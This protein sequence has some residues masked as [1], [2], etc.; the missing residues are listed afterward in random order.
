MWYQTVWQQ[1]RSMKDKHH[2][3]TIN[4]LRISKMRERESCHSLLRTVESECIKL[5]LS[6]SNNLIGSFRKKE[7]QRKRWNSW[8][9]KIWRIW[10]K[11]KVK[12]Q[13]LWIKGCK[14][15]KTL[16]NSLFSHRLSF[17][18]NFKITGSSN[19]NSLPWRPSKCLST[20]SD[21]AWTTLTL[22]TTCTWPLQLKSSKES[23]WE[24]PSTI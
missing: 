4:Y 12:S 15:I 17:E 14:S 10:W 24:K 13:S 7:K 22:I 21:S 11:G 9:S 23:S 20:S 2:Q 18:S 5:N 6:I 1:W 19:V 16:K 3:N 8:S